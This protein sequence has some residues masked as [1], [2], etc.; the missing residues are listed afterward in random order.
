MKA[1]YK[2]E[3]KKSAAKEIKS[4]PDKYLKK[5]LDK[6]SSLS[7]TPR[8]SDCKK[9]TGRN[10]YRLRV[11]VYRIIYMIEDDKLVIL[12][13]KVVHRKNVYN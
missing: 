4:L 2:I 12:V 1:D 11:G 8:P 5:V 10:E 6:I 3:F 7:Q 9:L 13:I